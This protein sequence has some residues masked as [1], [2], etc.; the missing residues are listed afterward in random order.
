MLFCCF[1]LWCVLCVFHP[2]VLVFGYGFFSS[3]NGTK[4]MVWPGDQLDEYW[5][6]IMLMVERWTKWNM[7]WK[8][9]NSTNLLNLELRVGICVLIFLGNSW[10][11]HN[12]TMKLHVA[13]LKMSNYKSIFYFLS[14]YFLL[15]FFYYIITSAIFS[16]F[17]FLLNMDQ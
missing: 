13:K 12:Y 7:S 8:G 6:E 14:L 3:N 16:I 9:G 1:C 10:I 15:N 11:G 4:L 5:S 2:L 17:F